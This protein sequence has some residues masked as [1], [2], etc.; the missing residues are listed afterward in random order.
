MR[1]RTAAAGVLGAVAMLIP[2]A[3]AGAASSS[4]NAGGPKPFSITPDHGA[5]GTLVHISGSGCGAE[6][7]QTVLLAFVGG[8]RT[9]TEGGVEVGQVNVGP[10]G[11]LAAS[12]RIPARLDPF[13]GG[14]GGPVRPGSYFFQTV[15]PTCAGSFTVTPDMAAPARPLPGRP[16]F[17][18]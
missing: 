15:P 17:T 4:G 1:R 2:S 10:N 11:K 13:H 6:P 9:G 8:G 3:T 16:N 5:I 7:A 14:G 18:G 12:F